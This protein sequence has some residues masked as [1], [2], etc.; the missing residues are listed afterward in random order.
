MSLGMDYYINRST[1][2]NRSTVAKC[3]AHQN[4]VV[5]YRANDIICTDCGLVLG[6]P[7]PTGDTFD[8]MQSYS[9]QTDLG[10][11]V[12]GKKHR[13]AQCR[14]DNNVLN[15]G[16]RRVRR[17]RLIVVDLCGRIGLNKRVEDRAQE[18]IR[19]IVSNKSKLRQVK[20]D[21]LL[22]I[23]SISMA[24]RECRFPYTFRELADVCVNVKA[25]EI[26]RTFKMYGRLIFMAKRRPLVQLEV[27]SYNMMIPRFCGMLGMDFLSQKKIRRKLRDVRTRCYKAKALNP[28]T[29]FAVAVLLEFPDTR[30]ED[31]HR[32][33]GVSKHTILKSVALF[34]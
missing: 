21:E 16:E 8:R 1:V 12:D 14:V 13:A 24:C 6:C 17:V 28:M 5:D 19:H 15:S 33:T 11:V 7:E 30:L 20:K 3:C 32:V 4:T 22:C 9:R 31:V 26:C 25:K 18:I 34:E 23:V 10:C 27:V 29:K 2:N